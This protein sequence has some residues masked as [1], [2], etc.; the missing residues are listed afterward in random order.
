MTST[1]DWYARQYV[2]FE[3]ERT[4]P[5]KDLLA[6]VP[7]TD[8]RVAVDIG[9]GPGNSTEALAAR[10]PDAA[11]SGLDSSPDMIAAA[12]QRLP[13]FQFDVADIGTWAAPGPYDLI[14]ANAVLQW[15]PDH[16]RL[17]PSL[18]DKLAPGGSL[19]VQ[20]PDNLDEPAHRLLRDIAADGPWAAKLAGVERTM[21]YDAAWYYALLKP[22]CAR[23]DVW[24]T[25]YHHPLAGGADAVVEWFKGSALRPF[26]AKLDDSEEPGF[27]QRYRD[28]IAR[29]YPALDD[30]TV[31][32]PFP[33]LFFV[34]TR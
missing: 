7:A 10:L 24:R 2:L 29:A 15:V 20:M 22:L 4:R 12:R 31:L 1:T 5:V 19:A 27:L 34:A 21:R 25:V 32:L 13:Q 18:V 11:V 6:A 23:V 17:L 30:G 3:N 16:P 9:C 14:L 8:V 33:R 28:E 26:L